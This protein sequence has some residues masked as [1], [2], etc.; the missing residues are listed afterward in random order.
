MAAGTDVEISVESPPTEDDTDTEFEKIRE[1]LRKNPGVGAKVV[2]KLD[3]NAGKKKGEVNYSRFE[4]LR[5]FYCR[6]W[7]YNNEWF[8][9]FSFEPNS[10]NDSGGLDRS[11]GESPT[12][13][14]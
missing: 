9:Y 6:I 5:L 3:S 2:G 1:R 7:Q 14:G 10:W 11:V 4:F 13:A 8:F 12:T